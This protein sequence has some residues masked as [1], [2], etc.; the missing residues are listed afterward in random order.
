MEFPVHIPIGRE[1]VELSPLRK[2]EDGESELQRCIPTVFNLLS[3]FV[4]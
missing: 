1:L 4:R 3:D 2:N